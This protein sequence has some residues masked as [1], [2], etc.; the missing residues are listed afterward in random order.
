M[1]VDVPKEDNEKLLFE[2]SCLRDTLGNTQSVPDATQA[3]AQALEL[4]QNRLEAQL[5]TMVRM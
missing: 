4:V 5:D 3:R 2:L 1:V